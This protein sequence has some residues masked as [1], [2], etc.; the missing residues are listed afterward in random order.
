MNILG[1][2]IKTE[3]IFGI[4]PLQWHEDEQPQATNLH[5]SFTIYSSPYPVEIKSQVC[6][7]FQKLSEEDQQTLR[8]FRIA[9]SK[10]KKQ[11]CT[12]LGEE[13]EE[14]IDHVSKVKAVETSVDHYSDHL[15]QQL[16]SLR[17]KNKDE[18]LLNFQLLQ[19]DINS[20]KTLAVL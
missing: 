9:Y 17:G 20:L 13:A 6:T 2:I 7:C 18:I 19:Q 10:L 15:L 14:F 11:I 5:Y 12:Y 8:S 16:V 4:S 3:S 1:H